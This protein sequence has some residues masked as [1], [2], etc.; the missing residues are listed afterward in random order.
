MKINRY[1]ANSLKSAMEKAIAELGPEAKILQVKKIDGLSNDR[2]EQVE[3]IA[4]VDDEYR[5][6]KTTRYDVR[7]NSLDILIK[8][9]SYD[10]KTNEEKPTKSYKTLAEALK[11]YNKSSNTTIM[12]QKSYDTVSRSPLIVNSDLIQQK[13]TIHSENPKLTDNAN[14]IVMD[15]ADR[16]RRSI[17]SRS[18]ISQILHECLTKNKVSGDVSYDILSLLNDE[19]YESKY[20]DRNP[21]VRDYLTDYMQSNIE[22]SGGLEKS[23]KV[24]ILIGP[25]GVGKTTTLAKLAAQYHFQK[26]KNVGLVTIDAYRIAAIDQLRTYAQIMSI[27]LKVALTPD[28]LWKCINDYND[29]DIILVDTPG[30]SHLNEKE[31]KSIEEFLEAAQP[32]DTHLLISASV[33]DD[34]AFDIVES[35]APDYVQ[36]LIFTKLD[37]TTSYGLI[38]N[39]SAKVKKP[40]SYFT[41]GQNVPDDI[42][43]ADIKYLVDLFVTKNRTF[44]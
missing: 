4:V 27:P 25:T 21:S 26:D 28:Q 30:R 2:L 15:D 14:Q 19:R 20:E 8:D 39:V 9:E 17:G 38:L 43:L 33:K 6:D 18:R 42:K 7:R 31:V 36:K 5:K 35:F 44:R 22:I 11:S 34:D 37:E 32:A 13:S 16:P 29:M 10:K 12:D 40:L 3:I 24:V 41:I 1:R 23:G